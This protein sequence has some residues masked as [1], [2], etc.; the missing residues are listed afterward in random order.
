[1]L[2]GQ[3]AAE[4]IGGP[5]RPLADDNRVV[6]DPYIEPIACDDAQASPRLARHDDLMLSTDLDA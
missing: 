2:S 3:Q 1:M 4:P 6:N 5:R